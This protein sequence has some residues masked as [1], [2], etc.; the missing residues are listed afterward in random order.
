MRADVE[1]LTCREFVEL[2]TDYLDDAL[3]AEQRAEIERHV[4]FCRGCSNYLEQ[5]HSTIGLLRRIA[6]DDP[7][8]APPDAVVAIFRQWRA[9]RAT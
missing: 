9:E 5:M 1:H 7:G 3:P 2:L 8:A 6:D 4:V